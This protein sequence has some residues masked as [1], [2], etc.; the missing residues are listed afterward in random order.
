[1][2]PEGKVKAALKKRIKTLGGRLYFVQFLGLRG[3]P[4]CKVLMGPRVTH[5]NP[6]HSW[7]PWVE[8]KAGKDGRLSE[9]QK[10]RHA[11]LRAAGEVVLVI[12]TVEEIDRWFPLPA[13]GN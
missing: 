12:C 4:D 5:G 9:Q 10:L 6:R 2:T 7:N 3:A 8:T 13:E 1:M 11:E